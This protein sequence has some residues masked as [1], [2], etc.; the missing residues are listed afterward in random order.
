MKI[1]S[2]ESIAKLARRRLFNSRK[3]VTFWTKRCAVRTGSRLAKGLQAWWSFWVFRQRMIVSH[4]AKKE[5][6]RSAIAVHPAHLK[7]NLEPVFLSCMDPSHKPYFHGKKKTFRPAGEEQCDAWRDL[8]HMYFKLSSALVIKFGQD[9]ASSSMRQTKQAE[10]ILNL[11]SCLAWIYRTRFTSIEN[12]KM[13]SSLRQAGEENAT[14]PGTYLT[15][16]SSFPQVL[17]SNIAPPL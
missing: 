16:T 14:L 15:C 11:Q 2:P 8:C 6:Q 9:M 1:A 13:R 5:F 10:L 7:D 12:N 4:S 17:L 3:D